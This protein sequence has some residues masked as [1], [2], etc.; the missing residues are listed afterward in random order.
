MAN[1]LVSDK[2]SLYK[3]GYD[4]YLIINGDVSKSFDINDQQNVLPGI[5]SLLYNDCNEIRAV[6]EKKDLIKRDDLIALTNQYNNCSYSEYTPTENEV[7]R[8]TKHNTDQVRLYVGIGAN[9]NN[10]SFFDN[11]ETP[12]LVGGLLRVGVEGSPSFLGRLQGN[13]HVFFEGSANFTGNQDFTNNADPVNFSINS[14]RLQFGIHYLF[15]KTG[16]LKPILGIG[17]GGTSDSFSGSILGNRFEIDGGNPIV[18][19]RLGA[20]FKLKN[21]KHIGLMIEY[22]TSFE[23]DLTFPTSDGIIPL[24]VASQNIGIG[25]NYIF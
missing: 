16:F 6:I 19:P 22:I 1:V 5:L 21:N 10:I 20:R 2:A 7:K 9:H 23:N 13:L 15:N 3:I 8:A 4:S 17:I 18:V 12:S 25:I 11:N 14:Y 24:E